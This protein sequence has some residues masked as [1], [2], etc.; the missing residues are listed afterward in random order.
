MNE[1]PRRGP[2]PQNEAPDPLAKNKERRPDLIVLP[3]ANV[4]APTPRRHWLKQTRTDWQVLWRSQIIGLVLDSDLPALTRLFDLRDDYA[5][6][7]AEVRANPTTRGSRGQ[8]R[9][10]QSA[11]RAN[12]LLT[13]VVA[14]E[15]AFGLTPKDRLKLGVVFGQAQTSL[16]D[17]R[18]AVEAR[19]ASS[20]DPRRR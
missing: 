12:Q 14:A 1:K 19:A 7:S 4:A 5:R 2:R 16:E 10:N 11:G 15:S 8:P 3:T 18:A 9:L 13:Q 20:Q 17:M 6:A